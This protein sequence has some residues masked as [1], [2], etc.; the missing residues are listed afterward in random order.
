MET[1]APANTGFPRSTPNSR[2]Q[3][4]RQL[5]GTASPPPLVVIV[6]GAM[7]SRPDRKVNV[8]LFYGIGGPV[9][10]VFVFCAVFPV[11][12]IIMTIVF[13][14]LD[15]GGGRRND[16]YVVWF[17]TIQTHPGWQGLFRFQPFPV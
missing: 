11:E 7:V 2:Q 13:R 6:R 3:T 14:A 5:H 15:M 9:V 12:L 1:D 16:I 10:S 17:R 8:A 4:L